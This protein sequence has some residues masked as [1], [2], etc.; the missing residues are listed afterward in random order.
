MNELWDI[1]TVDNTYDIAFQYSFLAVTEEMSSQLHNVPR[2][3]W[4]L[5]PARALVRERR[6]KAS[7]VVLPHHKCFQLGPGYM[8]CTLKVMADYAAS[9]YW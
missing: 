9:C 8:L 3:E 5:R 6:F 2:R 4:L 7:R 1:S